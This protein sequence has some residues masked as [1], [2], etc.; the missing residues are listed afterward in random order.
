MPE[1]YASIA[2]E[3][4]EYQPYARDKK[5]LS[6][7][8]ALPG[9]KG[10][11]HRLGGLEKED[12]TGLLNAFTSS[13]NDSEPSDNRYSGGFYGAYNNVI[14]YNPNGVKNEK[15]FEKM[16]GGNGFEPLTLSV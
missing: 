3:G 6:R 5:T 12:I 15:L 9:T 8:L 10:L 2:T 14:V 11:E 1:I 7:K 4:E 13:E 16:V